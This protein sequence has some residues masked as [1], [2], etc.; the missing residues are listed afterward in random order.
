MT[1]PRGLVGARGGAKELQRSRSIGA[2]VCRMSGVLFA[3]DTRSRCA[4]G[5]IASVLQLLFEGSA[6]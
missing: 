5:R 1:N 2:L 3:A 4:T 6:F